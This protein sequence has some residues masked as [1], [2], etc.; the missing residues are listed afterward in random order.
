MPD[1]IP[2][3]FVFD[4]DGTLLTSR[5][6]ITPR[7]RAAVRGLRRA[8]HRVAL[9]SARPPRSV[10]AISR[11]LLGEA[12]ETI[13]LNGAL[14]SR[15]RAALTEARIPP[16]AAAALVERARTLQLEVNLLAGWDWFVE[17]VGPG[18]EAEAAIVG[19]PPTRVSDA[20]AATQ[21]G[22]HKILLIGA[23]DAVRECRAW[24]A[25]AAP[26]VAAS[27]SKPTYCE[28]VARG[29][30]KAGAVAFLAERLGIP[31]ERVVAFGD[32]E[33]D[34]P[35]VAGAGTG[36]AMGNAMDAVKRAAD[37]VT[38]SNDEDGIVAALHE[39]GFAPPDAADP[40]A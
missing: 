27:L 24:A 30:S 2:S 16:A 10:A 39:L 34:L 11:E 22:V 17:R 35:M 36:V 5:H 29:V 18:V 6:E 8:G 9:A 37:L 14:V 1:A 33:N 21:R 15:G 3:L 38:G 31:P 40:T 13:A 32:G 23:E 4:L 28:A 20:L 26:G 19:F 12:A 7:T 25:R